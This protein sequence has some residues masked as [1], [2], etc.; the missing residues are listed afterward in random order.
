MAPASTS[1]CVPLDFRT[2]ATYWFCVKSVDIPP[3]T[4][5]QCVP[6]DFRTWPIYR[7]CVKSV[8]IPPASTGQCVPL[9]FRNGPPPYIGFAEIRSIFRPLLLGSVFPSTS[10]RGPIYWF[11]VK[12]VDIPP[13]T[14]GKRGRLDFRTGR[15]A[16]LAFL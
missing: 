7:L 13:A 15:S 9:D 10:V 3:A 11:C 14:S 1:Q 2:G 8:D 16:L 4:T 12:S 5:R 6:L